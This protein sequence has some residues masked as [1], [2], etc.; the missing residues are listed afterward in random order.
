MKKHISNAVY[1]VLDYLA[2]PLGMLAIAPVALRGL[3]NDRYGIWMI[4][5]SAISTGA[6]VASGF[7]DANI[8]IVAMQRATGNHEKV[9]RAVRSSMGI[10]VVLGCSIAIVAWLLS[11]M[12]TARLV[13]GT[14]GLQAECLWSLR[15]ACLL[16]PIRAIESVCISTQR[17]YEHY[18]R[19]LKISAV[20]RLLSLASAGLLPFITHTVVSVLAATAIITAIGVWLQIVQVRTQLGATN[21]LPTLDG[22]TTWAL[23]SFGFFAWI[24]AVSGLAFGQ[25][26]RLMSGVAFGAAAVTAYSLCV[27]LSQPIYGVAAAGLHFMFPRVAAQHALDDRAGVR[28]TVLFG[29][30]VN[31]MI[32]TI[33]AA[34]VLAF[35]QAFL[36][37]WAGIEVARVSASI[38]PVIV[39]STTF[40]GLGVAGAYSMLAL[41]RARTLTCFTLVAGLL[42][43]FSMSW[44]APRYGLR[45]LAWGRLLYGPI[46]C[47]VY[48]PL[49]LLLSNRTKLRSS[50]TL[51]SSTLPENPC[52]NVLGIAVDALNLEGALARVAQVLQSNQKGYVCAVGVHGILEARRDPNVARALA[53]ASIVVPDGTPTV[54]VGRMQNHAAMDHVTG[55]ALMG[56]IFKRG[57]FAR[58]THFFYGGKDGVAGEL[59]AN[60]LRQFPWAHIVGTYTPPFRE[61]TSTEESDLIAIIK[62]RKPDIIWI[63]ISTPRQDLFMHRMLPRLET[64]MMFGV[65]A[66]FDFHSGHIKECPPWIKRAGLHWLHRLLQD[67]MRLW[68]RNLANMPFLWHIAL[69]LTGLKIYPVS[70]RSAISPNGFSI[71]PN[72]IA[73][74]ATPQVRVQSSSVSRRAWEPAH[75]VGQICLDD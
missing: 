66:A 17:A 29:F 41:G 35:G 71:S 33:G 14:S 70:T 11:P 59:A 45:G 22:E 16:I 25:L 55:P 7:G 57:E 5:I 49:L 37:I 75:T 56:E 47:T 15:V 48:F 74:I 52:A 43:A 28:R 69:Q 24:Q 6:I 27:Q 39:W 32:V 72:Q 54:W 64:R 4:A 53:D 2:Y 40:A 30:C 10:H 58:Y 12:V 1:G 73:Q 44:L 9:I 34:A 68:R 31:F 18:G 51:P 23:I 8:R 19:A 38:L 61:L 67:P 62:E 26:D 42:M 36:R 21:L 13:Q 3:G 63:G 20:T 65:G 50:S 46:T 60:M